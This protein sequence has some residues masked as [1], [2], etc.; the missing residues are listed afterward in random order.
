MIGEVALDIG[1]QAIGAG[2]G[3]MDLD[4]VFRRQHQLARLGRQGLEILQEAAGASVPRC[5]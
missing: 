4:A 2:G 5:I 1:Q 3:E